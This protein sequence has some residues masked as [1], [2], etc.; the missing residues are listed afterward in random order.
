VAT[1]IQERATRVKEVTLEDGR[2]GF[3]YSDGAIRD[4]NGR[5]MTRPPNLVE[6]AITRD[7]AKDF[8]ARRR[9]VGLEAQLRGLA[10]AKLGDIN[11]SEV[12][13]ELLAQA[14]SALEAVTQHMAETFMDS[15]NLRGMG[16]VY[17]KLAAP[18]V[19]DRRE[20]QDDVPVEPTNIYIMLSQFINAQVTDMTISASNKEDVIDGTTT[21][22]I[23]DNDE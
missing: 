2:Q 7:N 14:G 4:T 13:E 22:E 1:V 18:L 17:D 12:P 21:E 5:A 3:L 10:K 8:L 11:P 15:K 19:G 6:H 20:K 16:E 9:L 23:V